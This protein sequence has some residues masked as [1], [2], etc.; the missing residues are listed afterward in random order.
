MREGDPDGDRLARAG[1]FRL[2]SDDLAIGPEAYGRLFGTLGIH[3]PG[4]GGPAGI[5]GLDS[6]QLDATIETVR[7][8]LKRKGGG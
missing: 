4:L 8:Q 7:K 6:E 2:I 1:F 3:V 5:D